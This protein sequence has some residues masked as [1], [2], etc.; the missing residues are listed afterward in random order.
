MDF[1]GGLQVLSCARVSVMTPGIA[2]IKVHRVLGIPTMNATRW[3]IENPLGRSGKG[4]R[5]L[6]FAINRWHGASTTPSW[7]RQADCCIVATLS[8]WFLPK[9]ALAIILWEK[10]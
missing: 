6:C 2:N 3:F 10:R 9:S 5:I 7:R 1:V 4:E 8:S